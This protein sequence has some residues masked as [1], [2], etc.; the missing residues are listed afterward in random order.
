[1]RCPIALLVQ[2]FEGGFVPCRLVV[3]SSSS[4]ISGV[5]LLR[6]AGDDCA[7]VMVLDEISI[8]IIIRNGVW[9]V[10][11]LCCCRLGGRLALSVPSLAVSI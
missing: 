1:M 2:V 6:R 11:W 7:S 3:A 8:S 4:M 9:Y 10:V 5:R